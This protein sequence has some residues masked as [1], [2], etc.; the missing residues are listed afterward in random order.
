MVSLS[1]M[2]SLMVIAA[3]WAG[4][5]FAACKT[6]PAPSAPA[7]P[8]QEKQETKE[9][10]T[11]TPSESTESARPGAQEKSK[12]SQTTTPQTQ[13]QKEKSQTDQTASSDE[14][15]S[16][17]QETGQH[18]PESPKTTPQT[19]ESKLAKARDDLRVSQATEKRIASELEQLKKSGNASPEDI[20][21][22]ETYLERVEAMSAEN[23]KMV[24]EMERAYAEHPSGQKASSGS[25]KLSDQQIPEEQVQDPVA[26]LD[27][28]LNASL[29]E[30]DGTLLKEME[31]IQTAS[32]AKMRSLAQEAAEAANRLKGKGAESKSQGDTSKQ[33]EESDKKSDDE[34]M[35]GS[36]EDREEEKGIESSKDSKTTAGEGKG[37]YGKEDEDIVARQLREAA[38]NETDPELKAK[39][40]EEYEEYMKN[41][42]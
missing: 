22:Y 36:D 5:N 2:K 10:G 35:T 1:K 12:P 16:R 14:T 38:E 25:S 28:Q 13:A 40:W 20:R 8:K 7:P 21:N 42:Q 32:T 6:T 24:D 19:A 11:E 37:E 26:E 31:K 3:L 34:K 18:M 41:T 30:F 23:R 4:L 33:G 27:R 15:E 9:A 29:T 39:L 17:P